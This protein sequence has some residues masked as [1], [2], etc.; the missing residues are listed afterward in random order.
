[1]GKNDFDIDFDFDEEYN[2]DPKAF[3]G[4]DEYNDNIDLDAFSDEE[5][6]LTYQKKAAKAAKEEDFD[7]EDDLDA[8]EF[9]NMGSEETTAQEE[10]PEPEILTRKAQASRDENAEEK[11]VEDPEL[12]EDAESEEIAMNENM[13]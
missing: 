6:G 7:L 13:D 1:M 9:L 12:S 5:L 8:D 2:F 11:F 3:L 4:T 10:E